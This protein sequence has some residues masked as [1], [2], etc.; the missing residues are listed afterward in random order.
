MEWLVQTMKLCDLGPKATYCL[1]HILAAGFGIDAFRNL[2]EGIT[3]G[4]S[5]NYKLAAAESVL[6]CVFESL[7][8]LSKRSIRRRDEAV[9]SL[10]QATK[11]CEHSTDEIRNLSHQIK[12]YLSEK[13]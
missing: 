9:K 13:P 6:S 3:M 11:E 8:Y 4:D 7:I 5:S 2:Y 1:G 10:E 12:G